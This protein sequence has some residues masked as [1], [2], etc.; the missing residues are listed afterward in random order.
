MKKRIIFEEIRKIMNKID[1][2]GHTPSKILITD[3]TGNVIYS[4][5]DKDK[6]NHL[7]NVEEDIKTMIDKKLDKEGFV[8]DKIL[9]TDET[10]AIKES[11]LDRNK[12]E[13]LTTLESDVQTQINENKDNINLI[14]SDLESTKTQVTQNTQDIASNAE[15]IF[16]NS[17]KIE[18]VSGGLEAEKLKTS[19]LMEDLEAEKL[20]IAE[21]TTNIGTNT[22]KITKIEE[23]IKELAASGGDTGAMFEIQEAKAPFATLKEK[24]T[25]IEENASSNTDDIK[26]GAI[27]EGVNR[28]LVLYDDDLQAIATISKNK[29]NFNKLE[30]GEL[31]CTN[32]LSKQKGINLYVNGTSGND[33]NNGLTTGTA[34]KTITK[35]INSLNKYLLAD[36]NIYVTETTYN[37]EL[38]FE[39]FCGL[40]TLTLNLKTATINGDILINSCTTAVRIL[41]TSTT[42]TATLNHT[43]SNK[44]ACRIHTSPYAYIQ[45]LKIVGGSNTTYGVEVNLGGG[46]AIKH[47]IINNTST[48]AV[49]AFECSRAYVIGCKGSNNAQYS[50]YSASGSTV[51][52]STSIPDAPKENWNTTGFIHGTAPKTAATTLINEEI[53]YLVE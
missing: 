48:S 25:D 49:V 30:V 13:F 50:I 47:N 34:F 3:E 46:A 36:V 53:D 43:S 1:K 28:E 21:N 17:Q 7:A 20:K 40:G 33:N 22:D 12:L 2:D 4:E 44:S 32:V 23:D 26:L 38:I 14:E 52:L 35:A 19:A 5:I 9:I 41:G 37:E 45:Y 27:E 51:C 10:G 18:E 24:L 31:Y 8:F 6:L 11:N 16:A 29:S 39:G 42:V 15:S